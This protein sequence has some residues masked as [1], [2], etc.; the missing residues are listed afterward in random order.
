MTAAGR[1]RYR[2][3]VAAGWRRWPAVVHRQR[4]CRVSAR[5][6]LDLGASGADRA[7]FAAGDA[8]AGAEFERIRNEIIARP[9]DW[10][11]LRADVIEM[12]AGSRRPS[13]PKGGEL[14]DLKHDSGGLVDMEFAGAGAALWRRAATMRA[15]HGN[16][17]LAIRAGELGLVT[18]GPGWRPPTPPLR[19]AR[20][21]PPSDCRAADAPQCR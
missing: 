16:I 4:L 11:K 8:A 5:Q 6:S 7:R 10:L 15:D 2:C 14:F 9:R 21:T 17:A 3:P 18:A 12:R 1:L 19:C 20:G 13:Q